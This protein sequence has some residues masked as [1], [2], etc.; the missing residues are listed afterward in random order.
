MN[1]SLVEDFENIFAV[2][3]DGEDFDTINYE[4]LDCL[5]DINETEFTK[6]AGNLSRG[7]TEGFSDRCSQ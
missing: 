2:M 1:V 5:L 6:E 7:E 4:T 3:D